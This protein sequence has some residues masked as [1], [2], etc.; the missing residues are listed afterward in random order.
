MQVIGQRDGNLRSHRDFL[1]FF[2]L[3][4]VHLGRRTSE[5]SRGPGGPTRGPCEI[6]ILHVIALR[7]VTRTRTAGTF[8]DVGDVLPSSAT[9]SKHSRDCWCCLSMHCVFCYSGVPRG[10]ACVNSG[11]RRAPILEIA[12]TFDLFTEH[13]FP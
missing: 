11:I 5:K 7:T 8:T 13:T 2:W 3:A 1:S 6:V 9:E 12:H 10:V 4:S